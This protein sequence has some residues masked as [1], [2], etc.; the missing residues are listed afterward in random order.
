[1]GSK[2]TGSNI[3]VAVRLCAIASPLLITNAECGCNDEYGQSKILRQP[4]QLDE[5][6]SSDTVVDETTQNLQQSNDES[7]HTVLIPVVLR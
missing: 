4:V 1:M 6:A 2:S 3:N 5:H 7:G